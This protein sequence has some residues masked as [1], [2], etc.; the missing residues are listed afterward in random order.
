MARVRQQKTRQMLLET[1]GP[2]I[3]PFVLPEKLQLFDAN[4]DPADLS[5]FVGV[6][7]GG[8]AGEVLGKASSANHDLDWITGG[9]GGLTIFEQLTEPV[10]APVG[11][12]WIEQQPGPMS[13]PIDSTGWEKGNVDYL[14]EFSP[15]EG[16][17]LTVDTHDPPD[18]W[19]SGV[20]SPAIPV[21]DPANFTVTGKIEP[22]AGDGAYDVDLV[23]WI[24][25]P[26][27][28][29]GA[30]AWR[31]AQYDW[32]SYTGVDT[33]CD[34]R[35]VDNTTVGTTLPQQPLNI[36]ATPWWRFRFADGTMHW[37]V[38]A[39]G[40]TFTEL[41]AGVSGLAPIVSGTVQV[42]LD[43][44]GNYSSD[45]DWFA[46][47]KIVTENWS[48]LKVDDTTVFDNNNMTNPAPSSPTVRIQSSR[49][50]VLLTA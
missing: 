24:R 45:D 46:D 44:Y 49:G 28:G 9:G 26:T 19:N 42:Q 33:I 43:L 37:E 36:V 50:W 12:I 27:V 10:D 20:M 38:S 7:E 35:K 31:W 32:Y 8:N 4:G 41:G 16:I 1:G 22:P 47:P 3:D 39:D 21:A 29:A 34:I 14:V 13:V 15:T 23:F 6:P 5:A 30:G 18:Q 25:F 48:Y 2:S 40:E 17:I 11:A